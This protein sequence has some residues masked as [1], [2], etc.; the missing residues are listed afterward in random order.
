MRERVDDSHISCEVEDVHRLRSNCNGCNRDPV[1]WLR[2]DLGDG[3]CLVRRN[4][5]MRNSGGICA[6]CSGPVG[7]RSAHLAARNHIASQFLNAG[8][9]PVSA[10]RA[11]ISCLRGCLLLAA[12]YD[13]DW[14][15]GILQHIGAFLSDR[16]FRNQHEWVTAELLALGYDRRW[17]EVEMI[18]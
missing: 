10:A 3:S 9:P 16:R 12:T 15:R 1:A 17:L 8:A 13:D 6:A 4:I 2:T 5:Q 18:S 11:I 14:I 7:W